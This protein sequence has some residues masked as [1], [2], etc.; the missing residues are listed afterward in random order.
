MQ[1]DDQTR[2]RHLST[3]S[4]LVRGAIL[5]P[6]FFYSS[7]ILDALS[8]TISWGTGVGEAFLQSDDTPMDASFAVQ[9]GT[10]V[11]GF[12][13]T[14]ENTSVWTENWRAFDEANT[15]NGGYNPAG[16]VTRLPVMNGDGT[17]S[18]TDLDV[19]FDFRSNPDD[20]TQAY[21]WF[22]NDKNGDANSEWA[23][24]T[25]ASWVFPQT[26]E[27]T[28]NSDWRPSET[29][30]AEFGTYVDGGVGSNTFQTAA[31]PEPSVAMLLLGGVF[32]FSAGRRR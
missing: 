8:Q 22:F 14:S 4:T 7:V 18:N 30:N 16:F 25:D 19:G 20:P 24:V 9:L 17:T 10:F 12:S 6:A 11:D 5:V 15:E 32:C 28:A 1:Q 26:V 3:Y 21:M 27:P 2:Y 13:P 29:T 31:V 23:L